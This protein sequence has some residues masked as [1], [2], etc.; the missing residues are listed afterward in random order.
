MDFFLD[1][2]VDFDFGINL[3]VVVVAGFMFFFVGAMAVPLVTFFVLLPSPCKV[4]AC[5]SFPLRDWIRC[6]SS[7]R[8]RV[9][10]FLDQP[11]EGGA[12]CWAFR[13]HYRCNAL[14]S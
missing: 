9:N 1:F 10:I 2:F 4:F 8:Q 13:F 6:L 5:A 3:G 7:S 11:L 14:R 12:T